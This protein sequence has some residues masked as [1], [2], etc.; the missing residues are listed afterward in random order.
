VKPK[1]SAFEVVLW[2]VA[3]GFYFAALV[4]LSQVIYLALGVHR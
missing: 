4:K 3:F 2:A 1:T